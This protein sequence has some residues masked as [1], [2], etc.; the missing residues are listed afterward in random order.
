VHAIEAATF[1]GPDVLQLKTFADPAPQPGQV[2]IAASASDVLFVDTMIRSG[3]GVDY[4]PIRPPYIPGNGVGGTVVAAGE[5]VDPAWLGRPVAAH[6]GGAGGT[7]GYAQLAAVDLL[8]TVA[9]PDDVALHHATAVLHDGTTALRIIETVGVPPGEW[10]LIL[11]AA[12]GMGI[13]LVQLLAAR[14]G[15]VIGAVGG[16]AKQKVIGATG[17]KAAIDY[18]E[19]GW[20]DAV[21]QTT[22]GVRPAVV[23]DG[24]GGQLGAQ[25]FELV[26]DGGRFSAHGSSS[27]AFAPLDANQA[28]RRGV[29]VTTIVDL[30]YRPDDRSRLLRAALDEVREG[31]ITP[32]VGQTF[33]LADAT[34]AHRAIEARETVAKT[35]L[36]SD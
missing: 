6:T 15:R 27:G 2:L 26:A 16:K 12:G 36:V 11:G 31:A 25:A 5:R 14:G 35:L 1:G 13:L 3:R 23:L 4:F 28:G 21:L 33:P 32:V 20:P 29:T 8:N 30:Q 24:V 7:G 19:P 10:A 18:T 17:A 9:V 22:G 34:R